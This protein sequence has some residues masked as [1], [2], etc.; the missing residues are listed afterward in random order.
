MNILVR[1]IPT[2]IAAVLMIGCTASPTN[3][4]AVRP[5]PSPEPKST[6]PVPATIDSSSPLV[7]GQWNYLFY[8]PQLE[9]VV[10]VN[11]G[12]D[13]GKP[14]SDPLE[15]WAWDGK[16][17]SLLSRDPDGP[18]WRNFQAAAFDSK[19]NVLIM[20][21]GVQ[22]QNSRMQETWEWDG[23]TW[24]RF[25]VPG[26]GY[27]EGAMMAY[28]AARRQSILFGGANE[29][30]EVLGDTWAWDGAQWTQVSTTG[31]APRFPS[32]IV[33]DAA[34]EKVLLF[35]GHFVDQT[36]YIN[37]SDFW[38]WDGTSWKEISMPG[39][40]PG[41]RNI[42]QMVFNPVNQNVLLFGGGEEQF[43]GD[44]WSWDGMS[45]SQ[46]SQSGA[47]VRSGAGGAYDPER[48][49]LVVFGGVD[50]PGGKAITDTWEWDG[51]NWICVHGCN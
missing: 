37:F 28:D 2:C 19:R 25:D 8:H 21:G 39:E 41:V 24:T 36:S 44:L 38:A 40:H 34:R 22:D 7:A 35:S 49:R 1:L 14:A 51:Q 29:K 13:R 16:Q 3:T 27:R 32:A 11:G 46:L 20:H 47:P 23:Q 50:K 15:L 12:P 5:S 48:N 45:W 6:S 31:A 17:W 10:L 4:P 9:Q 43:L 18:T 26:P 33:Y 30:F 42:S